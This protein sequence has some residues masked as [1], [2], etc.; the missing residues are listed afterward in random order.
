MSVE[1]PSKSAI[2]VSE[3]ARMVGLSRARFY[4][5]MQVGIFPKPDRQPNTGRPYYSEEKQ[6]LCL[7]VR[8]RNVGVNGVTVLF[9]SRRGEANAGSEPKRP[10]SKASTNNPEIVALLDGLKALGHTTATTSQ[11]EVVLRELYPGGISG[12]DQGEVL[13]AVF[14][15]LRRTT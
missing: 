9:Y 10:A 11:V 8:Q 7:E 6:R 15:Q 3:M 14:L 13:R 2:S 1:F 5:L 4:Q 12:L